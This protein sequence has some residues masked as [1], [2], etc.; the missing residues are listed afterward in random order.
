MLPIRWNRER[1]TAS[2]STLNQCWL[3][4][5]CAGDRKWHERHNCA[6]VTFAFSD[7]PLIKYDIFYLII[8][9]STEIKINS[10]KFQCKKCRPLAKLSNTVHQH[11]FPL[12]TGV[13]EGER[14][15][16]SCN[17]SAIERLINPLSLIALP[18]PF[19]SPTTH[20]IACHTTRKLLTVLARALNK[21]AARNLARVHLWF[22]ALEGCVLKFHAIIGHFKCSHIQVA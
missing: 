22:T 17:P 11:V 19:Q 7:Q 10:I 20:K 9:I 3:R 14:R 6:Y 4:R 18:A 2:S 21:N 1:K 5:R 16:R 12:S 13:S 15:L 8:W